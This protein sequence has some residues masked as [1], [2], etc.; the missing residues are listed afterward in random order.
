MNII[1]PFPI[2][3]LAIE[4][5]LMTYRMNFGQLQDLY[6]TMW[7]IEGPKEKILVD[8]GGEAET[9][10]RLGFPSEQISYPDKALARIGLRTNDIDIIILTHMHFDHVEFARYF[11]RAKIMVQRAEYDLAM[12]P[13]PWL[14]RGYIK[15][16]FSDLKN[17]E[18][19]E[20]DVDVT[21]GVKILYTPG[22]TLGSQSVAVTTDKGKAIICGLCTIRDN[23]DPPANVASDF[24]VIPPGVHTNVLESYD[25]L[26]L[27]KELADIVI[28]PH[29][30]YYCLKQTIP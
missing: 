12:N 5:S 19:I 20:G 25:S 27:I 13:H 3:K 4:K 11:S 9:N 26:A 18:L 10:C 6:A 1:R 7:L 28:P 29:D 16:M 24:P 17:F 2:A 23:F 21:K 22:H 14:A 15:D 30:A 8:T